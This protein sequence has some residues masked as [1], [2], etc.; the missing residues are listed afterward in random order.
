MRR[1][2][3][4]ERK[5]NKTMWVILMRQ[6]P[7]SCNCRL[8]LAHRSVGHTPSKALSQTLEHITSH[9]A[10]PAVLILGSL[11]A[12][13]ALPCQNAPHPRDRTLN[14]QITTHRAQHCPRTRRRRRAPPARA[15]TQAGALSPKPCR[16]PRTAPSVANGRSSAARRRLRAQVCGQVPQVR[17]RGRLGQR[18]VMAQQRQVARVLLKVRRQARRVEQLRAQLPRA[19]LK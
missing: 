2:P 19:R 9:S 1:A 12:P 17:R 16:S 10:G 11:A 7:P 14:L 15:G 4:A 6:T 8:S 3:S 13:L 18:A 5:M